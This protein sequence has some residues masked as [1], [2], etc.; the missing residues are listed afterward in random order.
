MLNAQF[1]SNNLVDIIIDFS[2]HKGV[3]EY[4]DAAIEHKI[5]IIA[6][7]NYGRKDLRGTKT[8]SNNSAVIHSPNITLG[9]TY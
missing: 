6:I 8:I 9:L 5:K 3:Y 2:N 1:Y 4:L 7:S